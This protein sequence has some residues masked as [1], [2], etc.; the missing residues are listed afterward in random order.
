MVLVLGNRIEF[1]TT[2]LGVL[3]AR[4]VAVPVNPRAVAGE[5]ARML[6]D[7]GARMAVVD[8][9]ADV[10]ELDQSNNQSAPII[11]SVMPRKAKR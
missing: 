1:V 11:V 3:R 10:T 7:S 6:A 5:L 8:A 2:Y 4:L 9:G